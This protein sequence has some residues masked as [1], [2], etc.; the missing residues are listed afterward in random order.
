MKRLFFIIEPNDGS[1]FFKIHIEGMI[2]IILEL[3]GE[4]IGMPRAI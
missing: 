3:K 1:S 2:N 4:V